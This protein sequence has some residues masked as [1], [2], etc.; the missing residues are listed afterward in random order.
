VTDLPPQPRLFTLLVLTLCLLASGGCNDAIK[1]L[2]VYAPN[3]TH[4]LHAEHDPGPAML[5]FLD[6]DRQVRIDCPEAKASVLAWVMDPR[7][8]EKPRGTIVMLHG[9][10]LSMTWFRGTARAFAD[11]GYRAILI[12]LPGHGHSTG[13]WI[14]FGVRESLA[15]H[16]AVDELDRQRLI[17]GPLG[18]WGISMGAVTA[19]RVAAHDERVKAVVAIAPYTNMREVV[20]NA[21]GH[22]L[23]IFTWPYS[24]DDWNRMVDEAAAEAQFNPDEAGAIET[25]RSL[26]APLLVIHGN[27]DLIAP[28]DHGRRIVEAAG[29]RDKKLITTAHGHMWAHVDPFNNRR[30]D[31]LDWFNRYLSAAPRE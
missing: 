19:I 20:P 23:P 2:A 13:D 17:E 14:T 18:L 28:P 21:A 22:V 15:I 8:G 31:A 1:T 9:Y 4:E 7:N 12:D 30:A 11:A 27:A 26:R 10:R 24:R 3:K 5:R 29:S 25:V 16:H 6:V